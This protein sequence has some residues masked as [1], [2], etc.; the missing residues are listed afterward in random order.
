MVI[1]VIVVMVGFYLCVIVVV[2]LG[3]L[4]EKWVV[5]FDLDCGEM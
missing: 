5:M 4:N 2:F 3:E 1:I